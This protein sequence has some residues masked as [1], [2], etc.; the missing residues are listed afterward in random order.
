MRPD[1]AAAPRSTCQPA[2]CAPCDTLMSGRASSA[3]LGRRMPCWP[4]TRPNNTGDPGVRLRLEDEYSA[5]PH[6]AWE[7]RACR[8][9]P[10]AVIAAPSEAKTGTGAMRHR[11][12]ESTFTMTASGIAPFRVPSTPSMSAV[13]GK[14]SG[15]RPERQRRRLAHSAPPA[16][17]TTATATPG[18]TQSTSASTAPAPS[19]TTRR[20]KVGLGG[21]ASAGGGRE[22]T[23]LAV[24]RTVC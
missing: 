16:S 20:F 24:L 13:P 10:S 5:A 14:G 23:C 7:V 11:G 12:C 21:G 3:R 19:R 1:R 8:S 9:S 6:A 18:A 22:P 17:T 4:S 15:P 2:G